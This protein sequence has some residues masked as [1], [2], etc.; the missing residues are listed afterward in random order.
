MS[1]DDK[2]SAAVNVQLS[3]D[4]LATRCVSIFFLD[5]K[6]NTTIIVQWLIKAS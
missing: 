1:N 6:I 4:S 5:R 2:E 3:A